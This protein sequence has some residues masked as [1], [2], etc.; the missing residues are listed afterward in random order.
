MQKNVKKIPRLDKNQNRVPTFKTIKY[1]VNTLTI[2]GLN[3]YVS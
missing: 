1:Y 3:Q 2:R